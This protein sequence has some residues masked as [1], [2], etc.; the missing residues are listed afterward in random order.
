MKFIKSSEIFVQKN[1]T[2]MFSHTRILYSCGED[3]FSAN[4]RLRQLANFE[5]LDPQRFENVRQIPSD[6][7]QP[8]APA[9]L[10]VA[11]SVED[12]YVK[13]PNLSAFEGGEGLAL[14]VL[15]EVKTCEL[16]HDN[17]HTNLAAYYG[18]IL[19]GDRIV[20]LCFRRYPRSLMD[21]VN[22]G[23][24]NKTMFMNAE[25]LK[26]I[27]ARAARY[28]PLLEDGLRHIHSLKR[29]HN[30]FNPNNIL[31]T[32][33]DIPVISDFDSSTAPGSDLT[34][35]RVKR[36]HGW[37]NPDVSTAMESNDLDALEELRIWLTGS[38]PDEYQFKE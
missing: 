34:R 13:T 1:D 5:Q 20:G 11:S 27:R 6:A 9:G 28:I 38:S 32:D 35:A 24:L 12:T 25:E 37:F 16:I 19:R 23:S 10:V 26:P 36:T 8:I 31:I 33:D 18:C 4:I 7:Y 3:I 22:P 2:F 21:M 17:P 14:S 29:I 15:E 30:D